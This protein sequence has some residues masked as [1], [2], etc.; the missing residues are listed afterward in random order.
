MTGGH[1]EFARA[2]WGAAIHAKGLDALRCSCQ[3]CRVC[4]SMARHEGLAGL[5]G[6]PSTTPPRHG[7]LTG[8]RGA[9]VHA[10]ACMHACMHASMCV[11]WHLTPA[12]SAQGPVC[13]ASRQC[14][15]SA[16]RGARRAR[17]L[18]AGGRSRR[19]SRRR[20]CAR[21]CR[22]RGPDRSTRHWRRARPCGRGKG[23]AGH[24]SVVRRA[25]LVARGGCKRGATVRSAASGRKGGAFGKVEGAPAVN[26]HT[27]SPH[28]ARHA[29]D[30]SRAAATSAAH[31]EATI[32]RLPPPTPPPAPSVAHPGSAAHAAAQPRRA[33]SRAAAA[34]TRARCERRAVSA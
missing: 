19:G 23:G 22:P 9:H 11:H 1:W 3:G 15:Q 17:S 32:S 31:P 4:T 34:A 24:G 2:P 29:C 20:R 13:S 10:C 18:R 16:G 21:S 30:A 27:P 8:A 12:R 33:A 7:L 6:T 5:S 25:Q 14:Q 28:A 26:P